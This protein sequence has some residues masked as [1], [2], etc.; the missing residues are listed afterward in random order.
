MAV[1]G[2]CMQVSQYLRRI[3]HD[4]GLARLPVALLFVLIGMLIF[5][6]FRSESALRSARVAASSTDRA[7]LISGLVDANRRLRDEVDSL[8]AKL[9]EL[10]QQGGSLVVMVEELNR[11]KLI[12][13]TSEVS[14]PG[15]ALTLNSPVSATELQD[16]VNELKNSG[17]KAIALNGQRLIVSSAIVGTEAGIAVDG[18][19]L[20]R[21]FVFAVLGDPD[22]LRVALTRKGGM[23]AALQAAHPG[24]QAEIADAEALVI[25]IYSRK[26]EFRYAQPMAAQ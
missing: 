9:A 12:T 20:T 3:W 19:L 15:I 2:R 4:D 8:R 17:A 21:P 7:A 10:G 6:Q 13:G 5:V 16:M 1:L 23:L 18:T 22:T 25:P 11:L 14:G 24:F 26:I